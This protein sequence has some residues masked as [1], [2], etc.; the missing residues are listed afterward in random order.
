MHLT[1]QGLQLI[2]TFE[3]FS[4]EPYQDSVGVWTIGYGSTYTSMGEPVTANH[5]RITKEEATDLLLMGIGDAEQAVRRLIKVPLTPNQFDALTSF[6]YNVGPGAL[7]RSTLRMKL[8]RA[9]YDRAA[10]ELLRWDKA[11][12][13]VLRGLTRRRAAERS[14]FLEDIDD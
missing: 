9:Q 5:S 7:Q 8:N 4:A 3:G 10:D 2:Q 12:G 6:T 14:L 1:A 11:G 13:N